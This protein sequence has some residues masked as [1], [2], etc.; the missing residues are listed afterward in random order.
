MSNENNLISSIM[1]T[2]PLTQTLTLTLTVILTQIPDLDPNS[3]PV[4]AGQVKVRAKEL[5]NYSTFII[6]ICTM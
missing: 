2:P 4:M 1:S 5:D 3:N 6:M